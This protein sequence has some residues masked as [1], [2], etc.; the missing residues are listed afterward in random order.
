VVGSYDYEDDVYVDGVPLEEV[1]Q[2]VDAWWTAQAAPSLK[3]SVE[4]WEI[5]ETR[6]AAVHIDSD[7]EDVEPY[8]VSLRRAF[9]D[10]QLLSGI[11]VDDLL[12]QQPAE[13]CTILYVSGLPL[14]LAAERV[15]AWL[16]SE[17]CTGIESFDVR[18]AS[19]AVL[20]EILLIHCAQDAAP[21]LTSLEAAM[22][23]WTLLTEA[24]V[25]KSRGPANGGTAVPR[26]MGSV[27]LF[28]RRVPLE[29]VEDR[30]R[31]W[32]YGK[33]RPGGCYAVWA[34]EDPVPAVQVM[35]D[36]AVE[37]EQRTLDSLRAALAPWPMISGE[38]FDALTEAY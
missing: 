18:N 22:A 13:P 6:L 5:G 2:R 15:R 31:R 36:C 30:A 3:C 17:P 12:A 35:A 32:W 38:E 23:P 28:V 7:L 9:A 8:G 37:E 20:T 16:A 27:S 10:W 19:P 21:A 34:W 1:K 26:L 33:P 4:P 14:D 24:D 29:R 11:D 25:A